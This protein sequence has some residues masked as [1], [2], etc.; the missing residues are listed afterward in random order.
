MIHELSSNTKNVDTPASK[1][2]GTNGRQRTRPKNKLRTNMKV[3]LD[4]KFQ[5]DVVT[6]V[7]YSWSDEYPQVADIEHHTVDK[8]I[9]HH[10]ID[11]TLEEIEKELEHISES[12]E[13]GHKDKGKYKISEFEM[14]MCSK[15]PNVEEL[16]EQ[17]GPPHQ[18][19]MGTLLEVEVQKK[20]L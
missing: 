18:T 20:S 2:W 15:S 19:I 4:S 3:V 13:E 14:G 12:P 17:E 6:I 11:Q 9:E 1:F 8:T 5:K 10:T 16:E 7:K